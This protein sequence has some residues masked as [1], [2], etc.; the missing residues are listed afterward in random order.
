MVVKVA[1]SVTA[2]PAAAELLNYVEETGLELARLC[3]E[4]G[5]TRAA[6][7]FREAAFLAAAAQRAH[8][9]AKAAPGD[10]A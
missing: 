4:T 1:Y 9:E 8:P 6:Q 7:S 2:D 10:A 3:E 5:A